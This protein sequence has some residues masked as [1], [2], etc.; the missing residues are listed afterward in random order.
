LEGLGGIMGAKPP[1]RLGAATANKVKTKLTV[2]DLWSDCTLTHNFNTE[3]I[4][5][6]VQ[7]MEPFIAMH[8]L[9]RKFGHGHVQ[10]GTFLEHG[11]ILAGC[12]S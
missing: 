1:A 5:S 11:A 6:T 3:Q 8:P 7:K 10:S 2:A 9:L 12:P 4:W